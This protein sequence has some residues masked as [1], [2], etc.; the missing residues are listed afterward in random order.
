MNEKILFSELVQKDNLVVHCNNKLKANSLLFEAHCLGL[1]W[2][3]GASYIDNHIQN[4]SYDTYGN[5]TCYNLKEGMYGFVDN[6]ISRGYLIVSFD[7][8]IF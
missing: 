6:Y 7:D 8:I 2:N 3:S 1:N 4:K 5:K